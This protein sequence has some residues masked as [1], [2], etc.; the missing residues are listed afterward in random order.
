MKITILALGTRGDLQP[1]LS[2]GL[3]LRQAGHQVKLCSSD[4]FED[5]A[6][7]RGLDFAAIGDSPK[8]ILEKFTKNPINSQ[9]KQSKL[10]NLY[11]VK[12]F[13]FWRILN[14][15]LK[16]LMNDAWDCC[17]DAEVI[18]YSQ[19]AFSGF[20]IAE[21]LN[22]PCLAT[23]TNPLT[24]THIYPHP[25]YPNSNLGGIYNWFTYIFEEQFRWQIVRQKINLWREE[26]KLAPITFNGI[27]SQQRKQKIPVLHCYSPN[28]LAKPSDWSDFAHVTGYWFLD[29]SP[30]WQ[31]SEELL[32][33]LA[34]G[35]P[36]VYVGFGSMLDRNPKSLTKL[37]LDALA[38]SKQRGILLG[39]WGALSNSDL[40]DNVLKI[41]SIPH[42][43]LFPKV[44]AVVHHGGAGTTAAG[45][46][47]GV[48]SIVVPFAADQPFWGRRVPELGVGTKPIPRKKLTVENLSTAINTVISD[49]TMK[50]RCRSLGEKIRSEN[51]V[52]Q[53]VEIIDRYLLSQ[54]T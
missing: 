8:A 40:P 18:I 3:G 49:E 35:A 19:L 37:V 22:I 41:D 20:N 31:P 1:Y 51:G 54:K 21:K 46:R 27:F 26:K 28:V 24:P 17:Q 52:A 5:F 36:P 11:L 30:E 6:R 9:R 2:L 34:A 12:K 50:A 44:A 38:A 10:L 15:G 42:D 7:S 13:F 32:N 4:I 29:R 53:A 14:S 33:F 25:L 16:K 45:F 48:P 43:W 23:Y 39:G 47:A